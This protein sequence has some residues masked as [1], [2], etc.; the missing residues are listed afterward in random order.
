M[1]CTTKYDTLFTKDPEIPHIR[2]PSVAIIPRARCAYLQLADAIDPRSLA[3]DNF[4]IQ[5][6]QQKANLLVTTFSQAMSL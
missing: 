5:I 4:E 2:M 3:R 1:L 6:P